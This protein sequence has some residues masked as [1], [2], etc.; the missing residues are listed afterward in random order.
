MRSQQSEQI[1]LD[2]FSSCPSF[3]LQSRQW[4]VL[5]S[6]VAFICTTSRVCV[7]IWRS[8]P[9][10][11]P[12]F[13]YELFFGQ[14]PVYVVRAAVRTD[15]SVVQAFY[16]ACVAVRAF[17]LYELFFNCPSCVHLYQLQFVLFF[18]RVVFCTS[19]FFGPA[20]LDN[21]YRPVFG[22][23]YFLNLDRISASSGESLD[24]LQFVPDFLYPDF[25]RRALKDFGN[26]WRSSASSGIPIWSEPFS[27]PAVSGEPV[28]WTCCSCPGRISFPVQFS[29]VPV[30]IIFVFFILYNPLN[31]IYKPSLVFPFWFIFYYIRGQVI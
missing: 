28:F 13:L 9:D 31:F 26:I 17:S 7:F 21:Q 29:G 18:V 10:G 14:G 19:Y 27:G 5:I 8:Y 11:Q 16:P 1:L 12:R 22:T 2:W 3:T 4:F 30:K 6:V 23:S 20:C 15:R 24:Q 25:L